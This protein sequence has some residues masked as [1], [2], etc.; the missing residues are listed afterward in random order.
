MPY[1]ES[2]VDDRA[3]V[4]NSMWVDYKVGT[5]AGEVQIRGSTD[6]VIVD[7]ES[8]PLLPTEVKTKD[9][10]ENT[11]EPN[12]HHV[13]QL[14]AYMEGLSREWETE[15]CD[16][17]IIYGD[18]TDLSIKSFH[19]RFDRKRWGEFVR[20][21]AGTHTEYRLDE[22]LP[23]A[24]PVFGWECNFCSFQNRCGKA[25]GTTFGDEGVTGFLP[26]FTYP[27]EKVETYLESHA[28]AKLTP[29]LAASYP[30]LVEQYGVYDWRCEVNSHTFEINSVEWDG[31]PGAYP[32][33]PSCVSDGVLSELIEPGLEE[34]GDACL[35]DL[36]D[37]PS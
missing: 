18:R 19:V 37:E 16:G 36:E 31:D 11:T 12:D 5:S 4:R 3:Y 21:W 30:D 35:G 34:Q 24:D 14:Y 9:S 7:E 10:I 22:E 26:G 20:D 2:I 1:L 8:T 6:P 33:C 15:V 13:A 27:Y 17:L 25:A 32:V 29:T 23:P 28:G